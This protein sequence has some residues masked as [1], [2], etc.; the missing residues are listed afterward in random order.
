MLR[1]PNEIVVSIVENLDLGGLL[2]AAH[3]SMQW[4]YAS[5]LTFIWQD[6]QVSA[7]SEGLL[8]HSIKYSKRDNG[9]CDGR[10]IV[11]ANDTQ[12]RKRPMTYIRATVPLFPNLVHLHSN[13]LAKVRFLDAP[14]KDLSDTALSELLPVFPNLTHLDV[15]GCWD[16]TQ[17]TLTRCISVYCNN[18]ET[19]NLSSTLMTGREVS[20]ILVKCPHLVNLSLSQCPRLT[21]ACLADIV[22]LIGERVRS[23]AFA[24]CHHLTTQWAFDVLSIL[25]KAPFLKFLNISSNAG[26]DASSLSVFAFTRQKAREA[27]IE[28]GGELDN[29]GSLETV[30]PKPGKFPSLTVNVC[31]C[32]LLTKADID[33]VTDMNAEMTVVGNS[34]LKDNSPESVKEYL[35]LILGSQYVADGWSNQSF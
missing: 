28:N 25:G 13:L 27:N 6:L 2:V 22:T 15:S 29:A 20:R 10:M 23:L 24:S 32:E 12:Y 7:C 3:V 31:D 30:C 16:L 17:Y 33:E 4:R 8:L 1:I 9:F 14:W 34:K 19:L 5:K 18:I 35:T 26:I 11:A 21:G